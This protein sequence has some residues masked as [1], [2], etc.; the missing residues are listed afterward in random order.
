MIAE[1]RPIC[2]KSDGLD[3]I[4]DVGGVSG[5]VEF[6]TTSSDPSNKNFESSNEWAANR[7]WSRRK[8]SPKRKI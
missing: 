2:V 1:H 7:G 3:L 8:T 4:E 6:L 5:F